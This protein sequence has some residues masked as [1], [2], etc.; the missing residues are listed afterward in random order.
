MACFKNN[1][2][3]AK[4]LEIVKRLAFKKIKIMMRIFS[5]TVW[6]YGYAPILLDR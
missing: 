1:I 2:F 5:P 6:T 3:Y 4:T